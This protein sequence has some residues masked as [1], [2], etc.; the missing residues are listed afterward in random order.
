MSALPQQIDPWAE[1]H[2]PDDGSTLARL[3]IPGGAFILDRPAGVPAVWGDGSDVLWAEGES[4]IIL[5]PPGVGKTTLTGQ[6]VRALLGL[7]RELLGY[8]VKP[9]AGRVL[10]LAMDRPA[11]IARSLARH[12]RP[13]ER[14]TLDDRLLVWKGPPPADLARHPGILLELAEAAGASHVIVDSLKD[15]A[16]GLKDDEVG[17]GWNRARQ[18]AIAAGVQ[19][20]EL[21]HTVKRGANGAKPTSLPDLYGSTWIASGAGSVVLLW[22]DAGDPIVELSHLKQ[23]AETVGPLRVIHDHGAGLSSV[24]H[25]TDP[26]ALAIAAGRAG[27]TA[28]ALAAAMYETEKPDRNQIERARRKLDA[29]VTS[30]HM[31]KVESPD[32][33]GGPPRTAYRAR[34]HARTEPDPGE[35]LTDDESTHA[36]D[37]TAGE[38]RT[39]AR[40]ARTHGARTH[41]TSP[42]G[43]GERVPAPDLGYCPPPCGLTYRPDGTCPKGE[44]CPNHKRE[45]R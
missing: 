36:H 44:R 34:T 23:P 43:E 27:I 9:A 33:R 4:C 8:S 42:L 5:G 14:A 11:Q 38:T 35:P 30:E 12:F 15:A 29:L 13:D 45:T 17:A 31:Q 39:H 3:M 1:P 7:S 21:H 26:V 40:T 6:I 18:T 10:Y 24:W 41:P 28:K 20:L 37:E 19:L 32:P 22:G 16:I 25:S 2:E